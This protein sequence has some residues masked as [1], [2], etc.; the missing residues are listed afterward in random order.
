[1]TETVDRS[2]FATIEEALEELRAGR[3]LIV[4]DDADR[5]N[6]GDFVMAAEFATPEAVNFMVTHG[7]GIVC[8]PTTGERL[9]ELRMTRRGAMDP[10]I[11]A[12][13]FGF[14]SGHEMVDAL[15]QAAPLEQE[16]EPSLYIYRLRMGAHV[17]IGIA[18]CFSV[19]EYD[20]DLIKKHF[21]SSGFICFELFFNLGKLS[22]QA[23]VQ[24]N[25][26]S[27]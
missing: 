9:E 3:M 18:G 6:E 19:D 23:N 15:R 11:V 12:E 13:A 17:Q 25:S 14:N 27:F 26:G 5:E 7:R 22:G 21:V 20:T 10:E 2:A 4:V 8:L 24:A 16:A 1:M